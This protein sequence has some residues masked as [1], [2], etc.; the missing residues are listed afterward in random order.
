M[1]TDRDIY[2][3]YHSQEIDGFTVTLKFI[4]EDCDPADMEYDEDILQSIYSGDLTW[5]I[6]HVQAYKCGIELGSAYLGGICYDWDKLE[7]AI[8]DIF[9]DMALEAISEAKAKLTE[10]QAA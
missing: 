10:L 3:G 4:N 6:A 7:C 2:N 1:T 8:T 9:H 5:L